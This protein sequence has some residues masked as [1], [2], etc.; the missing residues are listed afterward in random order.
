MV[1]AANDNEPRIAPGDLVRLNS[2]GPVML[3]VAVRDGTAKVKWSVKNGVKAATFP[4]VCLQ[5]ETG[6]AA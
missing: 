4:T 1:T 6:A 2:G 3:V 5:R